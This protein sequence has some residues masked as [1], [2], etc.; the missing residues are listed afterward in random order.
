MKSKHFWNGFLSAFDPFK[1]APKRQ[2]ASKISKKSDIEGEFRVVP[3][4]EALMHNA[5]AKAL[6]VL[7]QAS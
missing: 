6:S 3:E 7:K 1:S 4:A 2:P 5:F